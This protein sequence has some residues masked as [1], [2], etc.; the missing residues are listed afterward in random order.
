MAVWLSAAG[1]LDVRGHIDRSVWAAF[2]PGLKG[3]PVEEGCIGYPSDLRM[4]YERRDDG[5]WYRVTQ[6][7][8]PAWARGKG[9]YIVDDESGNLWRA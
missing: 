4:L 2:G 7:T 5:D 3:Y 9:Y 1:A 8:C 6:K